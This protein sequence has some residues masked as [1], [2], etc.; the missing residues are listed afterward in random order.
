M[1]ARERVCV[2]VCVCDGFVVEL[3]TSTAE[4]TRICVYDVISH[5]VCKIMIFLSTAII[6]KNFTMLRTQ[7]FASTFAGIRKF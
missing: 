1:L 4:R 7:M 2:C 3:Q 6:M 5:I